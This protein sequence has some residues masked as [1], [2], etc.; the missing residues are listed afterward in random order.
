[1]HAKILTVH[2]QILIFFALIAEVRNV[3]TFDGKRDL[4]RPMR[5]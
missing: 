2:F 4:E 3:Y 5:I 1:M